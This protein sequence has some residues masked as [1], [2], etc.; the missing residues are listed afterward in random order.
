MKSVQLLRL[1]KFLAFG[2][3][4]KKSKA[5]KSLCKLVNILKSISK[6]IERREKVLKGDLPSWLYTKRKVQEDAISGEDG[7]VIYDYWTS[8]A[9][10]PTGDK[11]DVIK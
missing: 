9:S 8:V 3:N 7:K 5:K 6:A 1:S 2:K 4:V 11:K 10:Q